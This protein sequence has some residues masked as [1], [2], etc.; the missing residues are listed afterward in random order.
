MSKKP[1]IIQVF[2]QVVREMEA[3]EVYDVPRAYAVTD[4]YRIDVYVEDLC[5]ENP[6]LW[7][8]ATFT[9]VSTDEANVR[10]LGVKTW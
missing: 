5:L 4:G 3:E 7:I 10:N 9:L 6:E 1:E 2:K 8:D